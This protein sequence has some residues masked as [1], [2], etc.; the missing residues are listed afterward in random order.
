M[1]AAPPAVR[2][3]LPTS[4]RTVLATLGLALAYAAVMFASNSSYSIIDDEALTTSIAEHPVTSTIRSLLAASYPDEHPPFSDILL[5]GWLLLTHSSFF[6]LRIFANLFYIGS[7]LVLALAARKLSGSKAYWA[8]ILLAFLWPFAY[9]YGRIAGWYSVAIFL[10]SALTLAYTA[11][12]ADR[13]RWAWFTFAILSVLLIWTNYF[14]VVLLLLFCADLL[15]FHRSIARRH[16]SAI[17]FTAVAVIVSF[18]PLLKE[19]LSLSAGHLDLYGASPIKSALLLAGYP[20]YATFASVAIAPW[21]LPLSIPVAI[22]SVALV[23]SVFFSPGRRWMVYFTVAL[24][25]LI[26]T[27][28][29]TVKRI[30][31][32]LPWFFLSVALAVAQPNRRN[33]LVAA[34]ATALVIA[35]GF[36]AIASGR[37]YATSNLLEPWQQVA[38]MVAHDARNGAT[39]FS[40]NPPFFF[41]LD[42][43]LGV[44]SD[45][46]VSD[47]PYLGADLYRKHGYA[48]LDARFPLD[49]ANTLR[50]KVVMVLGSGTFDDVT[51]LN[52]LN[53]ALSARCRVLGQFN[54][55][56]DP[57]LAWKQRYTRGVPILAYRV[58]VIWYDCG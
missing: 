35:C 30:T 34:S 7:T 55:T 37:H 14:S 52:L 54:S 18:L 43:Q 58:R 16:I 22:G 4:I 20:I 13:N 31:F 27:Q 29:L 46:Q 28:L 24:L 6:A 19:V 45:L 5:H 21:Y 44:L 8:V 36:T 9:Q 57:A 49:Q 10:L 26:L 40:V 42:D 2:F 48:I 17:A 32:L 53:D 33:S 56:P 11:I 39:V 1:K 51:A 23:I 25:L 12:L 50:G 3:H 47:G 41:N 15:I 38:R